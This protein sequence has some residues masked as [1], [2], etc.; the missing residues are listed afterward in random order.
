[1]HDEVSFG[2]L[3]GNIRIHAVYDHGIN[4]RYEIRTS[5]SILPDEETVHINAI[6][7]TK[8]PEG[9]R[10]DGLFTELGRQ[11]DKFPANLKNVNF[12]FHATDHVSAMDIIQDGI[13]VEKG[14]SNQDFSD[15]MGFYL[16][17]SF[18]F[19]KRMCDLP[20]TS[21]E[22]I[23][24]FKLK[25]DGPEVFSSSRNGQSKVRSHFS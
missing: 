7:K 10:R 2:I 24:V 8:Q 9:N 15:A 5:I 14:K 12:W 3:L 16:T 4:E 22:A 13:R 25:D 20:Y 21:H 23:I 11:P 18:D 19:A 6:N 17:N 1:M